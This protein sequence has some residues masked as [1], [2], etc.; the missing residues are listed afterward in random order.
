VTNFELKVKNGFV[1]EFDLNS[2][3]FE[4]FDSI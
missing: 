2:K 4:N 3:E 1:L